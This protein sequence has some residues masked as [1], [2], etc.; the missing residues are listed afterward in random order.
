MPV[1][2]GHQK[3]LA[4]LADSI[5]VQHRPM[6]KILKIQYIFRD[7]APITDEKVIAGMC[8][9]C[10]DR[11]RAI[12]GQDFIIEISKDVWEEATDEFKL[13][14]MDHELGHVGIRLDED[15]QPGIDEKSGRIKSYIHKHDIEEFEDV[16][17]RHG[18]YHKSLRQFLDAFARNQEDKKK[19]KPK[20]NPKE[21]GPEEE[22]PTEGLN[23]DVDL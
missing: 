11:N 9:R 22:D 12:H 5:I 14:L 23:E 19:K 1:Y 18:A 21:E 15:G 13:A 7:V 8:Y 16:L 2:S 3:D 17:E 6:L 10:D 20:T 4:A